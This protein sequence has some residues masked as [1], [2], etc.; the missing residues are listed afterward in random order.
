[1]MSYTFHAWNSLPRHC[2]LDDTVVKLEDY[3]IIEMN[4]IYNI[5][6]RKA[7]PHVKGTWKLFEM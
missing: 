4:E 1:M 2:E 7:S 5:Q 6:W 3:K